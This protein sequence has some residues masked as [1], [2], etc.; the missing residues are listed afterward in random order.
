MG[1]GF[2]R[3]FRSRCGV[4][5]RGTGI[6]RQGNSIVA[7]RW[8][9]DEGREGSLSRAC[10]LGR[11][12]R[13]VSGRRV[14]RR[15][16]RFERR[17]VPEQGLLCGLRPQGGLLPARR[18][19]FFTKHPEAAITQK[20]AMAAEQGCSRKRDQ[21]SPIPAHERPADDDVGEGSPLGDGADQFDATLEFGAAEKR[22]HGLAAARRVGAHRSGERRVRGAKSPVVVEGPQEAGFRRR[23]F[24]E[25]WRRRFVRLQGV[26]HI[27]GRRRREACRPRAGTD[28]SSHVAP[29]GAETRAQ[30]K[31]T[32]VGRRSRTKFM[33]SSRDGS[34][35]GNV[36]AKWRRRRALGPSPRTSR[37]SSASKSSAPNKAS[38]AGLAATI[39]AGGPTIAARALSLR[40]S[41]GAHCGSKAAAASSRDRSARSAGA[42]GGEWVKVG[43]RQYKS[44]QRA[45]SGR[46]TIR[47]LR[48]AKV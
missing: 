3:E 21:P 26:T 28:T 7:R 29:P 33:R 12:D 20:F 11:R 6:G 48:L 37:A 16:A 17:R 14:A 43:A 31:L 38:M 1:R 23:R 45:A 25:I 2:A 34:P 13:S 10:S 8:R 47:A 15:G 39:R 18:I 5:E 46:P 4:L 22:L 32:L 9:F 42:I 44:G 30:R 35:T 19:D 41:C 36:A 40:Q 24:A 27:G